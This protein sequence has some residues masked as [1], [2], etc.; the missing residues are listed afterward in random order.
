MNGSYIWWSNTG[1]FHC[2]SIWCLKSYYLCCCCQNL[3]ILRC[4]PMQQ[5]SLNRMIY[6]I[7]RNKTDNELN[8]YC[9]HGSK[10]DPARIKQVRDNTSTRRQQRKLLIL[11]R[12]LY[13]LLVKNKL[14]CPANSIVYLLLFIYHNPP[15]WKINKKESPF[16][17]SR[18]ILLKKNHFNHLRQ[19]YVSCRRKRL[20]VA[21]GDEKGLE[22]VIQ[23]LLA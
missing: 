21:S 13:A 6:S 4:L 10:Y 2:A 12:R 16:Q 3:A 17:E 22:N 20:L 15:N 18:S 1:L 9:K 23:S 14:E 5:D 7:Y 8:E 19:W 11:Y